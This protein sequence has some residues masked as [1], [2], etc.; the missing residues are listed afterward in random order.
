MLQFRKVK[1]NK[2]FTVHCIKYPEAIRNKIS[3]IYA[4][5]IKEFVHGNARKWGHAVA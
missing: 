2:K 4:K 5:Y 3:V 1:E